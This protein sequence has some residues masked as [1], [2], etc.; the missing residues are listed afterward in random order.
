MKK[1]IVLSASLAACG[2]AHAQSSVTL[3][4]VVD[5]GFTYTSNSKGS[6]QIALTGGNESASRWG[7]RGTED[8]G[9]GLSAIFTLEA[10]FNP[11]N[12]T[13]GQNGTEFGRQAFVG[14]A[15]QS[16]GT[17]TLG[18]QYSSEADYVNP[19]AAGAT[20]AA[21]GAGYGTHPADLDNLNNSNRV[22]NAIKYQSTVWNG[23]SFAAFYSFGGQAGSVARNQIWSLGAGYTSGP[24]TLAAGYLYVNRP[25]FSFWGDKANDS[26]TASNIANPIISGYASAG[27]EHII[28]AG[29]QYVFGRA[30]VAAIYTNTQFRN[31]GA[32][33]VSGLTPAETSYSGHATFNSAE[34][35]VRY[36]LT[37]ALML[38]VSYDYTNGTG[39]GNGSAVYHTVDLG[40]TYALSKRTDLYAVGVFQHAAGVDSTGHEAV[41]AIIGSTP[42]TGRV[43]TVATVGIRHRF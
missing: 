21:S 9:G 1:L 26:T 38:A 17:V 35:N 4:G 14:V 42:S 31:L 34:L 32:V 25:N 29:A 41:A 19:L 27:S 11:A 13:M 36:Q 33:G 7:V 37:P 6:S 39:V 8:L 30:T 16:Y 22:N 43:Q 24:L 12:G 3:Y 40:A 23:L 5:A 20:W 10:G 18:R 2:L 15:S 28:A